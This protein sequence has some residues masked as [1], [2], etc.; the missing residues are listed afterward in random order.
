MEI[1]VKFS[2]INLNYLMMSHKPITETKDMYLIESMIMLLLILFM[3]SVFTHFSEISTVISEKLAKLGVKSSKKINPNL[4]HDH[5][6][7]D[8]STDE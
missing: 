8:E 7:E 3:V 2:S 4:I 6:P 5:E 1:T